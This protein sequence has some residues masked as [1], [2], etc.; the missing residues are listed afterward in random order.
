VKG[1]VAPNLSGSRT[2][3]FQVVAVSFAARV[4]KSALLAR[5]IANAI[6]QNWSRPAAQKH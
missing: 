3:N 5:D 4:R 2:G 6:L 1:D